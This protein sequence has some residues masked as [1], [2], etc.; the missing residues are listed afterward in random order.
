[1]S[2]S[3]RRTGHPTAA[4]RRRDPV[5]SGPNSF[6]VCHQNLKKLKRV[7]G[8]NCASAGF[9]VKP[10]SQDTA[11]KLNSTCSAQPMNQI[12]VRFSLMMQAV[13][14]H[15][16][17]SPPLLCKVRLRCYAGSWVCWPESTMRQT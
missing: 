6:S 7:H 17:L 11:I 4:H 3:L 14:D 1:M 12:L 10:A 16:D 9:H 2:V 15:L 5:D 8:L 13:L